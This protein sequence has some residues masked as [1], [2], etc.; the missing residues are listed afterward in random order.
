M[1][2]ATNNTLFEHLENCTYFKTTLKTQN[3]I[4]EETKSILISGNASCLSVL[5]LLSALLLSEVVKIKID[6][7]VALFCV[8][9]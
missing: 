4:H 6:K 3:R 7:T 9:R 5:S 8:I 2:S 1:Y